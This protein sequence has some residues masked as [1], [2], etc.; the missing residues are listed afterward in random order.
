MKN[1]KFIEA[2]NVL[3]EKYNI[4]IV[5]NSTC[6]SRT[7]AHCD[8]TRRVCKWKKV[9]S[10]NSLFTLAH[11]IGHIETNKSKYRRCEQEYYAT[12][13][14]IETLKDYKINVPDKL[15]IKYQKYIDREWERGINKNG[16]LPPKETFKLIDYKKRIEL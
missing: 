1:E 2:A 8:K 9:N 16:T 5:E 15:I 14:A 10:I 3:I 13:W 7:H 12:K 4:N 11:E 6:K